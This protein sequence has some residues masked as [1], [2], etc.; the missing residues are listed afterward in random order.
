MIPEYFIQEWHE[1][2]PWQETFMV[3]QGLIIC[4]AL[5]CICG[6]DAREEGVKIVLECLETYKSISLSKLDYTVC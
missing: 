3:E 6:Q 1:T 4:K 5:V 2:A